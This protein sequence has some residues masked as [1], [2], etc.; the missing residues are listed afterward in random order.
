MLIR[1]MLRVNPER[2]AD[3]FDIA[4]HWWLNLEENM[5]VIQELPENQITDHTPLTERA[6]TMIVQVR[7]DGEPEVEMR[8]EE[9]SLRGVDEDVKSKHKEK[10]TNDP[11]ERLR[12]IENRLGQQRTK[13]QLGNVPK[14]S[15]YAVKLARHV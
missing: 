10:E 13:N 7:K 8:S 1:N 6:E 15:N 5:P 4:S 2:R 11:L 9:K 3:I 14:T 12:Q